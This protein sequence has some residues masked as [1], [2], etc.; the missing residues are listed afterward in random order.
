MSNKGAGHEILSYQIQVPLMTNW[1][2]CGHVATDMPSIGRTYVNK[3]MIIVSTY[4][5]VENGM[6]L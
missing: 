4:C 5:K 3:K 2:C 6:Y 1:I